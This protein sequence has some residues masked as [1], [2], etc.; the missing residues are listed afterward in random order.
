M[1]YVDDIPYM[2]TLP[3][4][5]ALP[6]GNPIGKGNLIFLFS[7][8]L[9][10]SIEMMNEKQTFFSNNK[11]RW[12]FYNLNYIGKIGPKRYRF[13]DLKERIIIYKRVSENTNVLPYPT[14]PVINPNEQR[15][16]YYDLFR[17]YQIFNSLTEKL[18]VFRVI[19]Y[20][21]SFFRP[22]FSVTLKNLTFE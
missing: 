12:Y 20:F 6:K 3:K 14:R 5:P 4:K 9:E 19:D 10:T 16:T 7:N 17:Y 18:T 15:N 2:K 8:S 11:Y 21:W 13:K 22:I 1:I